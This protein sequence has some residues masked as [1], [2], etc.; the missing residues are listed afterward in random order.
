M[1]SSKHLESSSGLD[2]Q[3]VPLLSRAADQASA[4]AH[5]GVESARDTSRQLRDKALR[6][7]DST[8]SYIKDEPVKAL[9]IAAAAGAALVA[10][11][12][13]IGRSRDRG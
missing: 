8:V 13:L 3:D 2:N 11:A 6:V 7:S 5:R 1:F 10:M 9:L 12:S 4:L